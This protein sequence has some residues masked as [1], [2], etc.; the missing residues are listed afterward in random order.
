MRLSSRAGPDYLNN[1][2]EPADQVGQLATPFTPLTAEEPQ[3]RFFRATNFA[4]QP[5]IQ[6]S[7]FGLQPRLY[8]RS[9]QNG[10]G[11]NNTFAGGGKMDFTSGWWRD[12]VQFGVAG[13]TTQP[14]AN[15]QSYV[16]RTGLVGSDGQGFTTL[17][18]AWGKLKYARRPA[19][20]TV[21]N[22]NCRSCTP[23]IPA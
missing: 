22:W 11:V 3:L 13:Y 5:F 15:N 17:G 9:L 10:S 16:D 23:T 7:E 1:N 8:Y 18:E 4:N 2:V 21:R 19:R 14:I 20:F 6:D 12:T